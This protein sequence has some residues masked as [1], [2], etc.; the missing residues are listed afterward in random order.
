MT[1]SEPRPAKSGT[2]AGLTLR[3]GQ[4]LKNGNEFQYVFKARQVFRAPGVL[5]YR[6]PNGGRPTRLGVSVG[7]K[8]GNAVARNRLKRVF[9]EAFRLAQFPAGF[10]LVLVPREGAAD[11]SSSSVLEAFR[12]L[13]AQLPQGA[14]PLKQPENSGRKD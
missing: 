12:K 8:H 3:P 5:I 14:E 11:V 6:A 13:A 2:P 7:K 4:R 1:A 10:D 9:R